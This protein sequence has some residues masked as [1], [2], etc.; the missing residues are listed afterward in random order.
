MKG[1]EYC[2]KKIWL[3]DLYFNVNYLYFIIFMNFLEVISKC[4]YKKNY[5]YFLN[6][7]KKFFELFFVNFLLNY[8][9]NLDVIYFIFYN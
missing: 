5:V 3:Y 9:F 8:V 4:I 2:K 1:V 7:L 6:M